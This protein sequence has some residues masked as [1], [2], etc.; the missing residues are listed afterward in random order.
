MLT[1]HSSCCPP[2]T[3]IG[4]TRH[5]PRWE[6][7]I[8]GWKIF[9][10]ASHVI[11]PPARADHRSISVSLG[12]SVRAGMAVPAHPDGRPPPSPGASRLSGDGRPVRVG[13]GRVRHPSPACRFTSSMCRPPTSLV[14][15]VEELGIVGV[16]QV[17]RRSLTPKSPGRGRPSSSPAAP[18]SSPAQLPV[19][20]AAP[21]ASPATARKKVIPQ[22]RPAEICFPSLI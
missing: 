15:Q 21:A 18:D 11:A 7:R 5:R 9:A 17:R 1:W 19:D 20:A 13:R 8:N 4:R 2:R 3:A 22:P 14:S 12:V 10:S 6:F 16:N